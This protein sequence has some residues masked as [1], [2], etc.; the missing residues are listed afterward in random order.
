M[1][2]IAAASVLGSIFSGRLIKRTGKYYWLT[3]SSMILTVASNAFL[4]LSG[5]VFGSSLGLVI[6]LAFAAFG[7]AAI[8]TSTLVSVIANIDRKDLAI[9]TA[10]SFLFRSIG[11][12]AGT[13]LASVVVQQTLRTQLRSRLDANDDADTIAER[14]RQSIKY[15][16]TLEPHVKDIVISCYVQATTGAFTLALLYVVL[17]FVFALWIRE[18]NLGK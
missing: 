11:A 6:S 15:I 1:I 7:G 14:V 2:G 4:V 8:I 9:A 3:V 17:A 5:G 16:K 13:S 12:G 10:C 18:K